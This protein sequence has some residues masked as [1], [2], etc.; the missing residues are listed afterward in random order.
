LSVAQTL[1][2]AKVLGLSLRADEGRIKYRPAHR[3]PDDFIALLKRDRTD[4]L[5]VLG[6]GTSPALEVV[7]RQEP[8]HA[9]LHPLEPELR[10]ALVRGNRWLYKWHME[11]DTPPDDSLLF[12]KMFDEWYE[13]NDAFRRLFQPEGCSLGESGPCLI[14]A[15]CEVCY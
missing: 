12:T 11:Y 8:E 1:R 6:P 5:R 10:D 13:R 2:R 9:E 15:Q 4:L 3:A 7:H 14:P